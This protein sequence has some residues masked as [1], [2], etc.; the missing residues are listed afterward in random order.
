LDRKEVKSMAVN[1]K[2]V[3]G[4]SGDKKVS[5]NFPFADSAAPAADV[6]TLMHSI[7]DNGDIYAEVPVSLSKA[8]FVVN[9]VTPVDLN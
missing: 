4:G 8:E 6:K 9:T 1:L 5:F 7:V 2:L 3:F